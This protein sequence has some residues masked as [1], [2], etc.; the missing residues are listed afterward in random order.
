[1]VKMREGNIEAL[2]WAI[3]TANAGSGFIIGRGNNQLKPVE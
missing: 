2:K 1:M 3:S